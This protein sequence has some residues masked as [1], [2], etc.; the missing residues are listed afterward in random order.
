[1]KE[2]EWMPLVSIVSERAAH[3]RRALE[4]LQVNDV[5]APALVPTVAEE[6]EALTRAYQAL[7]AGEVL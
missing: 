7:E 5:A 1:M 3:A 4:R 6:A 2:P